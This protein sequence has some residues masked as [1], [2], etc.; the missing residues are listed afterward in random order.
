MAFMAGNESIHSLVQV[1]KDKAHAHT[2]M[3]VSVPQKSKKFLL[4]GQITATQ[5]T[6]LRV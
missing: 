1:P 4:E 5:I 3:I 6:L 2:F